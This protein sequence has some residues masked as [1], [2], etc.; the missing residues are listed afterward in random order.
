ML[1]GYSSCAEAVKAVQSWF[2]LKKISSNTTAH[3]KARARLNHS[4]LVEIFVAIVKKETNL[5]E[6]DKWHGKHV[7]IVDGISL[8]LSDT[9]SIQNIWPQV[10]S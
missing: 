5:K 1:W 9:Q 6:C 2:P 4:R 8:Q 7:K 3:C 10:K